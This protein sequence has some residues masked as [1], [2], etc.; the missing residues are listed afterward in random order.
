MCFL[1]KP[2]N[3]DEKMAEQ[4]EKHDQMDDLE[5]QIAS[6]LWESSPKGE[7]VVNGMQDETGEQI[8]VAF[9]IG[10]EE[11]G[12]L[13]ANTLSYSAAKNSVSSV[14]TASTPAALLSMPCRTAAQV[15]TFLLYCV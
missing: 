15:R 3:D 12:K 13:P 1:S 9:Q 6:L 4:S 7:G 8:K 11:K 2:T 10:D 14:G 5:A